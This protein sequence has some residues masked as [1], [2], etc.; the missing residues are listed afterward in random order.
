[1][2]KDGKRQQQ[3]IS[4]RTQQLPLDFLFYDAKHTEELFSLLFF[5]TKQIALKKFMKMKF[6]SGAFSKGNF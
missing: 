3:I 5:L 4:Q 6:Q 1:M 2:M